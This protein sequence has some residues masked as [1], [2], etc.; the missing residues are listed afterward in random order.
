MVNKIPAA[1]KKKNKWKI[2]NI[3]P[4]YPNTKAGWSAVGSWSGQEFCNFRDSG[5]RTCSRYPGQKGEKKQASIFNYS[6]YIITKHNEKSTQLEHRFFWLCEAG[7]GS[8]TSR[9][10]R[11]GEGE[12]KYGYIGRF[13]I[14]APQLWSLEDQR[15][16]SLRNPDIW[17]IIKANYPAPF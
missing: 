8:S 14:K 3:V 7:T 9:G 11:G 16:K 12:R 10:W 15:S 4:F 6:Y 17:F 13:M 2:L 5:Q 1:L